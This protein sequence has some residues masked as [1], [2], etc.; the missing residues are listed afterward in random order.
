MRLVLAIVLEDDA[1]EAELT[2]AAVLVLMRVG[3]TVV[4]TLIA[5]VYVLGLIVFDSDVVEYVDC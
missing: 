2:T 1:P 5:V 3:F 4:F